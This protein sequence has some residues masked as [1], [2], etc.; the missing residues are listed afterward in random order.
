MG[1]ILEAMTVEPFPQWL[2]PPPSGFVEIDLTEVD[3]L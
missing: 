3:R 2:R 1:A